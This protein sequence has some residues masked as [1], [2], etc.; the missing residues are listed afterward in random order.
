MRERERPPYLGP[1]HGS[2]TVR[3]GSGQ[4][5][6]CCSTTIPPVRLHGERLVN[7]TKRPRQTNIAFGFTAADTRA[8]VA[9]LPYGKLLYRANTCRHTPAL[10][11]SS[12]RSGCCERTEMIG[13]ERKADKD[14]TPAIYFARW[15]DATRRDVARQLCRRCLSRDALSPSLP[16]CRFGPST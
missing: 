15:L 4:V 2:Y 14:Q 5:S 16:L 10:G 8:L 1:F 11:D 6:R 7:N 13:S 12:R 9:L 3:T